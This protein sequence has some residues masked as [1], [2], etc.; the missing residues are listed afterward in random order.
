[1]SI[2]T[3]VAVIGGGLAG[4]Y[5]GRL[6]HAAGIDLQLFE[7]RDRLGGRI[8]TTDEAGV[9]AAD[10]FDLGPSWFWPRMQ[11]GMGA[12]VEELGLATFAQNFA[13]DVI[14]ER[15]SRETP[16]R[17]H[18]RSQDAQS[19][20]LAGGTGALVTALAEGLPADRLRLGSRVTDLTL[21]EDGVTLTVALADGSNDTV[22]AAQVIAAL[23]PR[24]LEATVTFAPALDPVTAERW[25]ATGT[26]MAPHAKFFAF[27]DRP[28]WREAGLSGTAQSFAG[29]M[30]EIHDATTASGRAALFGFV[31]VGADY[32]ASVGERALTE[33]C[34]A[35]LVRLFGPEASLPRGTLIKDWAVDALTA[36]AADRSGG[37]HPTAAGEAWVTGR[38]RDRLLLAGSEASAIEPGFMAG[39]LEAARQAAEEVAGRLG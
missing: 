15:M 13:G 22:I 29:P 2:K 24:L 4:L 26:W 19:I 31:G 21:Q 33:A 28:F 1:M 3:S 37:A 14:V 8:L 17:Y 34:T 7:A 23:P 18:P 35:Q 20:R 39:A 6:L 30:A 5:T 16:Q 10:G 38:W 12:L 25:H 36:T 9:P 32:R 27:Y 11:P